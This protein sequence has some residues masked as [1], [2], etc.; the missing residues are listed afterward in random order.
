M[1]KDYKDFNTDA[2]KDH[3]KQAA[4]AGV[5]A[6]SSD[7]IKSIAGK[8]VDEFAEFLQDKKKDASC[9]LKSKYK[10]NPFI[11]TIGLIIVGAVIGCI[12]SKKK[13]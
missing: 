4:G 10:E 8:L 12:F 1:T 9:T 2:V 11:A 7:N 6:L 5:E 3:V 13:N